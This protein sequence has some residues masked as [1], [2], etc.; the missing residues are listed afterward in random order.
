MIRYLTVGASVIAVVLLSGV[1][2]N[3]ASPV[4]LKTEQGK[5]IGFANFVAARPDCSSGPGPQPLPIL[6]EKPSNGRIG[7]Q[8]AS[9]DVAATGNCTV[10]R[11]VPS[12]ALFYVPNPDFVGV[13]SI[14]LEI[15]SGD[16]KVATLAYRITVQAAAVAKH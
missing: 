11:K 8:I 4:E 9:T 3:S 12:I 6:V 2:A 5:S 10:E 16:N 7:M 1:N 14:Q 15:D 13:D